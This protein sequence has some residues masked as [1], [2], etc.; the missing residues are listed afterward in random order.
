MDRPRPSTR[1]RLLLA[2]A[3][4]SLVA[5]ALTLLTRWAHLLVVQRNHTIYYVEVL[6]LL[7]ALLAF[8][9]AIHPTARSGGPSRN[10]I[11]D[12]AVLINALALTFLAGSIAYTAYQ[13]IAAPP[14]EVRIPGSAVALLMLLINGTLAMG[15][16]PRGHVIG[17]VQAAVVNMLRRAL[18][19]VSVLVSCIAVLLTQAPQ[20]SPI[21]SFPIA[22]FMIWASW[23]I[24]REHEQR[25]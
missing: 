23:W 2:V 7:L 15:R 18:R 6:V 5:V 1:L 21:I 3:I 8:D 25:S 14:T 16:Q 9:A 17:S 24:I 4:A 12:L 22:S 11:E 19:S 20:T 10:R 13:H